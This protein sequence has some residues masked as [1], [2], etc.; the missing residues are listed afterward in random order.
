MTIKLWLTLIIGATWLVTAPVA[1]GQEENSE[2]VVIAVPE[3]DTGPKDALG[4]GNPR[5]SI[6]GFLETASKFN[7]DKAAEYLDLRDLPKKARETGGPELAR[8]FN[9]IIARAVWFDDYSVTDNPKGTLGDG[10]PPDREELV[11]IKTSDGPVPIWMQRV[12][13][14]DGMDIWKISN[15]SVALIPDLYKEFSYSAPVETVRSWFPEDAAFLGVEA[16]K[17]LIVL[18]IAFLSWP[19]F[20]LLGLLLSRVFSSPKKEN[21]L[22]VKRI[23]TGPMI[24]IGILFLGTRVLVT[25]GVGAEAQEVLKAQTLFTV[26]AI[27]VLWSIL[28]LVKAYQQTKLEKRGRPGAAKLMQPLTTLMKILVLIFG[29]LFWLNN[30]GINITTLLA[31][32]GVGGLAVA[33]ALQ[34]P[35]EDMMG[36]LTIFSQAIL[37]VGDLVRYGAEIGVVEDIGLR[38]TRLR[39]LNNTVVSVPNARIASVETENISYRKMIR[40]QPTLRLRYDTSPDQIKAVIENTRSMLEQHEQVHDQPLRVRFSDFDKDALLIKINAFVKTTDFNEFLKV[41]EELNF[42]MMEIIATAGA[43]FALPAQ[44]IYLEGRDSD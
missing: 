3:V 36:A 33:L 4:R 2:T 22:L 42:N 14:G 17:W 8:Q 28:N 29:L 1:H 15:R 26:A 19:V 37:R 24:L 34:K 16:F 30:L 21:Y 39:T 18:V 5:D 10:L 20:Y 44:S 38:T 32:L 35:L 6:I 31:G 40:F 27:W 41:S 7:W 25:L 13:R 11:T 23:L 9:H 12:P 43:S